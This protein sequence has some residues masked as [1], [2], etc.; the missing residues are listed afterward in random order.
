MEKRLED[1]ETRVAFQEATIQDLNDVIISQQ[2]QIDQLR[3]ELT[4]L[5]LQVTEMLPSLIASQKDET[6]PPHY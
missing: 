3:Q 1:L 5:R 6:P 4:I 2:R